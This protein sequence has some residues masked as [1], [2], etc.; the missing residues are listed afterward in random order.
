MNSITVEGVTL[1]AAKS[2]PA[3]FD[4]Y[5]CVQYDKNSCV[6]VRRSTGELYFD[7]GGGGGPDANDGNYLW[8]IEH[9]QDMVFINN[10]PEDIARYVAARLEA[11]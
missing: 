8:C 7:G 10:T 1:Y 11:T 6:R 3:L 9:G 4:C 5:K 2:I